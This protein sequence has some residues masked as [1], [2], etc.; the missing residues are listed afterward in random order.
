MGIFFTPWPK[1]EQE[2]LSF[3]RDS[4]SPGACVTGPDMV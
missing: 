2:K 1:G 4:G 3:F